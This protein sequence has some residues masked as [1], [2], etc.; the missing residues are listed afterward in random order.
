VLAG[1]S[2]V[3]GYGFFFKKIGGSIAGLTEFAH[4]ELHGTVFAL[5]VVVMLVGAGAALLFYKTSS[6]DSLETKSPGLFRLIASKLWIDEAYLWYIDKVQQRV[7]DILSFIEQI[8]LAG[9]IIRGSAAVVGLFGI[10]A[11]AL[12]VGKVQAY[13]YWFILGVVVLWCLAAGVL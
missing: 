2:L 12:H 4:G 5:S 9:V 13:A 10:V 1:L 11:R 7:A 6:E 3:G 8:L